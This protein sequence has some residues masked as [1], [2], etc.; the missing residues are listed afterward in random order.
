MEILLY[1][2]Q[3][4]IDAFMKMKFTFKFYNKKDKTHIAK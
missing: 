1:K 2:E 4:E 3:I